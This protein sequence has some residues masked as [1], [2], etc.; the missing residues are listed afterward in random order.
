MSGD[1]RDYLS[2]PRCWLCVSKDV[3][4]WHLNESDDLYEKARRGM[5]ALQIICPSGGRNE[6]LKFRETPEGWDNIASQHPA[7]M[8]STLLGRMAVF[9]EQVLED[10]FANVYQGVNRAFDEMIVRLQNPILLLE[11]GLQTGHEY[12]STLMW[13]M[14]LDMLF[15]A[16]GKVPFVDRAAGFLGANTEVFPTVFPNRQ[17]KLTIGEVLADVYGLRNSVAHGLEVPALFREKRDIVDANGARINIDDYRYSQV[18][19]ESAL[20]LL[21]RSLREIMVGGLVD[22]VKDESHW[23]Q[24]LKVGARLAQARTTNVAVRLPPPVS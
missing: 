9:D 1:D 17:P 4:N 2:K 16:G 8:K 22:V 3:Q 15:M 5:Y 7:K 20:F 24:T 18:M 13:A 21:A 12:L 6:Y 11:H 14:G 19:M 23:K 10:D